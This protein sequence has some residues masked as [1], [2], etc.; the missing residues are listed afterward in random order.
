LQAAE[1][2]NRILRGRGLTQRQLAKL[3]DI[4]GS[5]ISRYLSG[6]RLP[7]PFACLI[8]AGLAEGA[9]RVKWMSLSGLTKDQLHLLANA[10][11]T[12]EPKILPAQDRALLDWIRQ[13]RGPVEAGIRD[14]VLQILK[15]T[16]H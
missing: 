16:P 6:D 8:L 3:C 9:D 1:L 11:G 10:L 5:Q 4:D 2:I 14:L 13:P 7:G 15:P 12:P